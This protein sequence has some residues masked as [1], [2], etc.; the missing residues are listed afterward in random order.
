M[1]DVFSFSILISM[2]DVLVSSLA[3]LISMVGVLF[4]VSILI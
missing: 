3:I 1:V 2:V 4:S